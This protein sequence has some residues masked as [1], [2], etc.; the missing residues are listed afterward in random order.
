MLA[1]VLALL[2][3]LPA[4]LGIGVANHPGEADRVRGL[5]YRYQYLTAGWTTWN[6]DAT[7]V[8]RYVA[9]SRAARMVPVLTYYAILGSRQTGLGEAEQ[10]LA[11][12]RHG[13]TMR[14]YYRDLRLA[15]RRAR[16]RRPVVVHVEPDLWGYLQQARAARLARRFA[17]RVKRLRDRHAPNVRLAYH[18]STWGT[19]EDPTYSKPS[20]AHMDALAARSA[21]F[22]RRLR[23]R[24]DLVFGDVADRDAG[25]RE[26]V[27]GDGGASRWAEADF[28]RHAAYLRGFTRR[29]RRAVVLWQ[30]PLGNSALDDTWGRYT[31]TRVEHW[32]GAQRDAHLRE[33]RRAG[34]IA[35]LFGAGADGNTTDVTDGG[36]FLERARDYL[37]SPLPL[38]P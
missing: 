6:E 26:H 17:T 24:F 32:L 33:L 28:T 25:F 18:L 37:R 27:L 2:A 7:F 1:L 23:T 20:L 38:R 11:N 31:D 29:T 13:P 34:V 4:H 22:Y 8:S 15:F 19:G 14:A 21:R 10:D 9:E 36:F 30:V 12:L 35:L 5:D 16:G 3:G